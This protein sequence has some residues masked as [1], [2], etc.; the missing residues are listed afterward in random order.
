MLGRPGASANSGFAKSA[1]SWPI[2]Q[3]AS[4][5]KEPGILL[6][7]GMTRTMI[8]WRVHSFQSLNFYM[9]PDACHL[10]NDSRFIMPNK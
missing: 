10:V 8:Q 7:L 6:T 3:R 4:T 5:R 2:K 1:R 9:M